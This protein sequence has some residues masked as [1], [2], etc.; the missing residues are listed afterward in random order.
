MLM[1]LSKKTKQR[2]AGVWCGKAQA[3]VIRM[4]SREVKKQQIRRSEAKACNV[5]GL[6]SKD[7]LRD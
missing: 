7:R 1:G 4:S 6:K 2:E 5:N 3:M